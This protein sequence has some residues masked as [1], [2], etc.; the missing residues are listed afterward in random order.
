MEAS[1]AGVVIGDCGG[2]P[3]RRRGDDGEQDERLNMAA[4]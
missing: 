1:R 2:A 3:A 4:F